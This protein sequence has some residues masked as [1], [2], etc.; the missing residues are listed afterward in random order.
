MSGTGCVQERSTL[1]EHGKIGYDGHALCIEPYI[2]IYEQRKTTDGQP[3]PG[4]PYTSFA[5]LK[6]CVTQEQYDAAIAKEKER[7]GESDS[8]MPSGLRTGAAGLA[9]VAGLVALGS[10]AVLV[11]RH[12]KPTPDEIAE[13][14][15]LAERKKD[16]EKRLANAVE[17]RDQLRQTLQHMREELTSDSWDLD[18]L[19]NVVGLVTSLLGLGGT[20][21]KGWGITSILSTLKSEGTAVLSDAEAEEKINQLLERMELAVGASEAEVNALTQDLA[22]LADQVEPN[23]LA[24]E[25]YTDYD[26]LQEQID[27][28]NAESL[29]RL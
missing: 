9:V 24:A 6:K 16:L 27:K 1:P 3:A 20:W 13:K 8:G 25:S 26:V 23:R 18:D 29:E 4:S 11:N 21:A 28:V 5:Y 15:R 2:G 19:N 14:E 17:A 7:R 12:R 22:D 10:A